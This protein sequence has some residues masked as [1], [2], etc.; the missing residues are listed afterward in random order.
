MLHTN[1]P[2]DISLLNVHNKKIY[3]KLIPSDDIVLTVIPDGV[4]YGEQ[5]DVGLAR[6]SWCTDQQVFIA[7][8]GRLKYH[9]LYA[10]QMLNTLKHHLSYLE[11][12]EAIEILK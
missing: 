2:L 12:K 6:T 11:M 4:K 8:V 3:L 9:G 1:L 7:V 5:G 10:V